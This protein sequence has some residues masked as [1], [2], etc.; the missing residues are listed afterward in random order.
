METTRGFSIS[1]V[2]FS[3]PRRG[4]QSDD[5]GYQLHSSEVDGDTRLQCIVLYIY[6]QKIGRESHVCCSA[7]EGKA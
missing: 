2:S 4:T 1:C 7:L 3:F 5:V 6:V